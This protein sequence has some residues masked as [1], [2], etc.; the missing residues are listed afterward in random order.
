[1]YEVNSKL[2]KNLEILSIEHFAFTQDICLI[3][4]CLF[5]ANAYR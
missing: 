3:N 5:D 1:M 2:K 4:M